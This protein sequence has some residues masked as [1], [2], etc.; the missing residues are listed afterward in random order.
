MAKIY[1]PALVDY[2]LSFLALADKAKYQKIHGEVNEDNFPFEPWKFRGQRRINFY[3]FPFGRWLELEKIKAEMAKE[4]CS[5]ANLPEL[6]AFDGSYPQ[7]HRNAPVMAVGSMFR[8][9]VPCSRVIAGV[10]E[11][12]LDLLSLGFNQVEQY[13][14]LGREV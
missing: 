2:G 1:L 12:C 7:Y 5:P 4:G 9:H 11:S 3:L 14:Y 8:R 13:L 6:M 10:N